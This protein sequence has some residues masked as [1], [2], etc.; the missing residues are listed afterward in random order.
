MQ[1]IKVRLNMQTGCEEQLCLDRAYNLPSDAWQHTHVVAATVI[2]QLCIPCS[3]S[4]SMFPYAVC[5]QV[6]VKLHVTEGAKDL[7]CQLLL[8]R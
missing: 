7:K 6:R 5:N 2:H 3:S 8:P 1:S 4:S